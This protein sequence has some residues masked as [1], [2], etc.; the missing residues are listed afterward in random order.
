ME[1]IATSVITKSKRTSI[2]KDIVE[3]FNLKI[4]G[5]ENIKWY[6]DEDEDG[7]FVRV[8]FNKIIER[9]KKLQQD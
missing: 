2:P 6:L 1:E 8:E 9:E 3:L 5:M 4:D 7:R